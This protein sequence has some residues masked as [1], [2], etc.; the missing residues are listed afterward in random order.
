MGASQISRARQDLLQR[1]IDLF[2]DAMKGLQ[3]P[4][5]SPLPPLPAWKAVFSSRAA[6]APLAPAETA[7]CAW[8]AAQEK[9]FF[10]LEWAYYIVCYDGPG[11]ECSQEIPILEAKHG[12]W[13]DT[14]ARV[15][16]EGASAPVCG[17]AAT[18]TKKE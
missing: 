16:E 13:L 1:Q 6:P 3:C 10:R 4:G 9:Y 7:R 12:A 15:Q 8:Y 5:V 14:L 11:Y 18:A 2:K 17:V